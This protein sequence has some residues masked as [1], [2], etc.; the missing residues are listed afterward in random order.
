[1]LE[2]V[3]EINRERGVRFVDK[4]ESVLGPLEGKTFAILGLAFKPDTDDMREAKSIEI[5]ETLLERKAKVRAYDPAAMN[6]AKKIFGKKIYFAKNSYDAAR[7]ANALVLLTEWREFK[8]LNLEKLRDSMKQ[9][10][11]FDGRNLYDPER[12]RRL[13]FQYYGIGRKLNSNTGKQNP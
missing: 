2:S 11:L 7:N 10:V 6:N 1:M 12:Q 9:P 13:G 3:A 4:M 8:L 5:I